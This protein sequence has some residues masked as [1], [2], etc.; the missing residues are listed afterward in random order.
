MLSECQTWRNLSVQSLCS[1]TR[2]GRPQLL[3]LLIGLGVSDDLPGGVVH[4]GGTRA[5]AWPRQEA[6]AAGDR[7]EG[8]GLRS[9]L[10]SGI[11]AKY[12]LGLTKSEEGDIVNRAREMEWCLQCFCFYS[13]FL[14]GSLS[15]CICSMFIDRNSAKRWSCWKLIYGSFC[16]H[17]VSVNVQQ[18]WKWD[19]WQL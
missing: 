19:E 2:S 10:Q 6:K 14:S 17:S 3:R 7:A 15:Y 5:A 9:D 8:T 18:M 12:R 16:Q 4:V 1:V 13:F 11:T